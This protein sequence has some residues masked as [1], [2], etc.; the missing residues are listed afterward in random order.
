M[1]WSVV[2]DVS[3][4]GVITGAGISVE[5]GIQSYRGQGGL[6]DDPVEGDRTV[7]A[8]SGP[9]LQRDPDRTW[10][11]VAKLARQSAGAAPNPGHHALVAIEAAVESFV[12]LTQNVDGLHRMAGSKQVIDIHGDIF[13]TVCMGCGATGRLTRDDYDTLDAAPRCPKCRHGTLRPDVV[14]FGEMLPQDKLDRLHRELMHRSPDVVIAVG[15]TAMFPY[16][17]APVYQ[18]RQAGRITIEINPEPTVLSD[19]VDHV[20]RATAG[21]ALPQLAAA[22]GA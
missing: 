12:L 16:I 18:A 20:V 5:S 6:Y 8:L 9:T 13:G 11:T 19:V 14:L 10:R 1:D 17:Q 7:E 15:T 4:V 3:S 22:L 2:S 21:A